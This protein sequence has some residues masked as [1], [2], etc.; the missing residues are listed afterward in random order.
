MFLI[1]T[2]RIFSKAILCA[3]FTI[4]LFDASAQRTITGTVYSTDDGLTIPS[5]TIQEAGRNHGTISGLDGTFSL[6]LSD[7]A[8]HII[9]SFIGMHTEKVELKDQTVFEIRLSPEIL[10]LEEVQIAVP[11]SN[12]KKGSFT[13]AVGVIRRTELEQ[14]ATKSIDQL[15][16][17]S[18]AGVVSTNSSGQPGAA[19]EIRIR[20]IGSINASSEPLYV[21]DGVPLASASQSSLSPS[22]NQLASINPSDIESITVL[23]DAAASSLYGSRASNGV[24]MITTK[25]GKSGKTN[26]NFNTSHSI[27]YRANASF[28]MMN[29]AEYTEWQRQSM[30]NAGYSETQIA[31]E[32]ASSG[33]DT[34][35]FGEVYRPAYAQ[36]YQLSASGGNSKTLFFSSIGWQNEE[37]IVINTDF[38][39]FS[40]RMNIDHEVNDKLNI[41]IKLSPVY[42]FQN[43]TPPS[44]D[45]ANPVTGAYLLKPTDAIEGISGFNFE[46]NIYN[47]IGIS[48]LDVN[49]N[50]S[51]RFIGNA[52]LS[53]NFSKKFVLK[54]V[55]GTD[56]LRF[57]EFKFQHPETPDGALVNGRGISAG[58]EKTELTT[59]NT[60]TFKDSVKNGELTAI[61]GY[62]VQTSN[63][64]FSQM[65]ASNYADT[66]VK[67]LNAASTPESATNYSKG[68]TILSYISNLQYNLRGKYYFSASFRRDGSSKFKNNQFGNFWSTGFSWR[69]SDESFFTGLDF[70]N[71]LK[72]RASY[73][74]SGNSEV[75]EYASRFLYGY[76]YNYNS[77]PGI[78]PLQMGNDDLTWE[79][80]NN[81]DLGVDF[82]LF[83]RIQASA[84]VYYRRTW[85]LLLNRPVSAANGFSYQMQNVGE[86]KNYGF[87]MSIA[88][89]I[90]KRKSFAWQADANFMTNENRVLKLYEGQDIV[91]GAKIAREG[92]PY[93]SFYLAE[94]AGVNPAD[95]SAIWLDDNGNLTDQYEEARR[96][97][98]GNADPSFVLS[99]N[100]TVRYKRVTA[101]VAFYLSY[102]NQIY[103]NTAEA[104]ISDG[105][106]KYNQTADALQYWKSPGDETSVPKPVYNNTSNSNE[107]S[108]RFL[109]DA[110][111]LRLKEISL[112]YKVSPKVCNKTKLSSAQ[113]FAKAS[114]LWTLTNYSGLDPE[115]NIRGVDF[116]SYPKAVSVLLGLNMS[117]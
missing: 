32:Q 117:F 76:G 60:L 13:G 65:V 61:A 1:N 91:K 34:D 66:R 48:E 100:N 93:N 9:V 67:S 27:S 94:W 41:G 40:S 59:S 62:E 68:W 103:N 113:I 43:S 115:Q 97:V 98:T 19:S 12:Q 87:E 7:S 55:F 25:K 8:S 104:I 38:R 18:I 14:N 21:I 75:D 46:N 54:S 95:G 71:S 109:E 79:K 15:M 105:A 42:S 23:K 3:L 73:G 89:D 77:N 63:S 16:Q 2:Y 82:R 36:T 28:K 31:L 102:G 57:D 90:L 99:F 4:F 30:L 24:I 56:Y 78:A 6:D 5:A 84:E 70:V 101:L 111:F 47:V 58:V 106:F 116:F 37:G 35:W 107:T 50:K 45:V 110:S 20:G 52:L 83:N 29:A 81:A 51:F 53:Y 112:S 114:N 96:I 10:N 86:M 39:K 80:N 85:D 74:T 26:F 92:E 64:E 33:S 49:Q 44:S 22:S 108:T 69:L 11:Y 72:I 88:A 17:G